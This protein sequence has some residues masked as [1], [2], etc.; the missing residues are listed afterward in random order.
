MNQDFSVFGWMLP[1]QYT[2]LLSV[3]VIISFNGYIILLIV[4]RKLMKRFLNSKPWH[5]YVRRGIWISI[6]T[7][8]FFDPVYYYFWIEHGMCKADRE[9]IYPAPPASYVIAGPMNTKEELDKIYV[10]PKD[11]P[12]YKDMYTHYYDCKYKND[13]RLQVCLVY[14]LSSI[15]EE[16]IL[17]FGFIRSSRFGK[18]QDNNVHRYFETYRYESN[19]HWLTKIIFG[20]TIN[21]LNYESL[22]SCA[23]V[24]YT[25]ELPITLD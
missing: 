11:F 4:I 5:K 3:P 13:S 8:M 18:Q 20:Y 6:L 23:R 12:V 10:E 17:P 15:H 24:N 16:K 7:L 25:N 9:R 19:G 2:E 14:G 1:K 21:F 22:F